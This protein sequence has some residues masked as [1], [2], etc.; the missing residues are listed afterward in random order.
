MSN[1]KMTPILSKLSALMN[2]IDLTNAAGTVAYTM[3]SGVGRGEF[4]S[5]VRYLGSVCYLV[6]EIS[7]KTCQPVLR[8]YSAGIRNYA[9]EILIGSH[10]FNTMAHDPSNRSRLRFPA[11]DAVG[12]AASRMLTHMAGG[13][14]LIT[15]DD[16]FLPEMLAQVDDDVLVKGVNSEKL[17]AHGRLVRANA[18]KFAGFY[19]PDNGR[20]VELRDAEQ[21]EHMWIV[22]ETANGGRSEVLVPKNATLN[23]EVVNGGDCPE[24][25]MGNSLVK[26]LDNVSDL[27]CEDFAWQ[28]VIQTAVLPNGTSAKLVPFAYVSEAIRQ[29]RVQ[30]RAVYEDVEALMGPP[31]ENPAP[32]VLAGVADPASIQA[33]AGPAR[34]QALSR[35]RRELGDYSVFATDEDLLHGM[36]SPN[37]PLHLSGMATIQHWN[38]SHERSML[39]TRPDCF[40][41]FQGMKPSWR[42]LLRNPDLEPVLQD[43]IREADLVGTNGD[44]AEAALRV[45]RQY[46]TL[47]SRTIT[48]VSSL[49]NEQAEGERVRDYLVDLHKR[50]RGGTEPKAEDEVHD[51]ERHPATASVS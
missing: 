30:A 39:L 29:K 14:N 21:P 13:Q 34:S 35:F 28:S 26:N 50:V 37:D 49:A 31:I 51:D 15:D 7:L 27:V 47:C 20:V 40:A 18:D 9:H 23:F 24:V 4:K 17:R 3:I 42:R 22:I 38:I 44:Y 8:G 2:S 1:R 33:S 36:Y 25:R 43:V 19:V 16:V 12:L 11:S 45:L 41:D 48:N 5:T 32:I 6:M 10:C 46:P